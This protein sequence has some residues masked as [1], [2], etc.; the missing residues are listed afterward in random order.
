MKKKIIIEGKKVQG[1]GYRPFLLAKAMRLRIPNYDAENVV[2]NGKQKIRVSFEGKEKQVQEFVEFV[3]ENYPENAK[4]SSVREA[5]P[6]KD[7]IPICEYARILSAEQQN[8]VIQAGLGMLG[9]Q[10]QTI[11]E[12]KLVGDKVDAV[13]DKVDAVGDEVKAVGDKVDALGD[14]VD[15]VGDEVKAVGSKVDNLATTTQDSFS[16]INTKYDIMSCNMNKILVE[17][18]KQ[19]KASD[20]RTEKLVKAILASKQ[21]K[22]INK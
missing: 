1:V 7:V 6:S 3:K 13:G 5:E 21:D 9:M 20:K 8:T 11:S 2:E 4:V 16:T 17:L 22:Q 10:S 12:V 14:K 19:R 18:I 15:A